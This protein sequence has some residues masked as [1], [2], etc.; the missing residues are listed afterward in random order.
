ML[1]GPLAALNAIEQATGEREVNVIG[2]CLGGTLLACLL[3]WLAAKGEQ[4][5]QERH[6]LHRHDRLH[7]AGR[8]RRVRGRGRAVQPGEEDGG[9]RLSRR[10]RDGHHLQSAARQRSDLV[11]RG[12]Q[13]SAGQGPVPL[14]PAVLELGRHAHAGEDAHVLS[15]QHVHQEPAG[16]AGR[17]HA[18]RRAD[19]LAKI[20]YAGL[21][22]LDDRRPHRAVEEHLHGREAAARAGEVH[23]GGLRAHRRRRQSAG[24]Q[25]VL[26]LDRSETC[27]DRRRMAGDGAAPRR[28]LVAGVDSMGQPV[29]RRERCRRALPAKASSSRSRMRPGPT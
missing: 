15:A 18:G 29:R 4:A 16:Q 22:R 19:R 17:H 25:Q 20:N 11:V 2:Y 6:L 13:L 12:Q 10:L 14:R 27:P 9:A 8:A 21:L 5:R 23:P 3:A 28:L 24:G 7:R 26:P 1:E